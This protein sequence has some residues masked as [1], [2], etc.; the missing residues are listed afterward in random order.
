[1]DDT[2][3]NI[4]GGYYMVTA[5]DAVGCSEDASFLVLGKNPILAPAYTPPTCNGDADGVAQVNITEGIPSYTY[6]WQ[7]GGST[8]DQLTG[9][10]AG[11]YTVTVTD[12]SNCSSSITIDVV[13]PDSLLLS[14]SNSSN[15]TSCGA[16]DGQARVDVTGG[17]APYSYFWSNS[18]NQ[19]RAIN[20]STGTFDVTVTD[21]LGCVRT[22]TVTLIDPNA[23]TIAGVGSS[24]T[25]SHDLGTVAVTVTGGTAPYSYFWNNNSTD[26]SQ[27]GLAV[28][29]YNVNVI[30]ADNCIQQTTVDVSG[31]DHLDV[32]FQITYGPAGDGDTDVDAVIT[33]AN[34]PYS[35]YQWKT[36]NGIFS[37]PISGATTTT[38]ADAM[39]GNYRLV[40]EDAQGCLDSAD[41]SVNNISV[42]INLNEISNNG[43][44]VYPN[45][46]NGKLNLSL[47]NVT[48]DLQIKV[49][50]AQGRMIADRSIASYS[51][52]VIEMD[53]SSQADG[54]Y[55]I[56]V[57]SS[58]NRMIQK[59]HLNR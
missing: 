41:V 19:K 1:M 6:A 3:S 34:S 50:D 12:S 24:V 9:L 4:P 52:N 42:G 33:G 31:P 5:T 48:G 59:V 56:E 30:D 18:Q 8:S 17:V 29:S 35:T 14:T 36:H 21:A 13:N 15:P 22:S 47:E 39:N 16:N 2:V 11:S 53:L 55:F 37:S 44:M 7:G 57:N 20:L 26:S 51:G 46:T 27:T 38:L 25:C 32:D 23:P 28:G 45:P 40:V 58:E 49:L 10:S 54:I 43:L